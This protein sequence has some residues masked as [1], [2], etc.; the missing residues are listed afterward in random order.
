MRPLLVVLAIGVAIGCATPEPEGC[1]ADDECADGGRC[2]AGACLADFVPPGRITD[3][4]VDPFATTADSVTLEFSAPGDDD[5]GAGTAAD[6]Y[7]VHIDGEVVALQVR[8]QVAG[9]RER[10]VV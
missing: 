5:F 7:A 8:P 2:F 9:Q 10:V 4:R 1:N 3:L 6:E